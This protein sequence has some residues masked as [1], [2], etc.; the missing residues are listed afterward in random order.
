MPSDRESVLR[1]DLAVQKSHLLVYTAAFLTA[2]AAHVLGVFVLNIPLAIAIGII[3]VTSATAIYMLLRR[4]VSRRILNPIWISTDVFLV[5]LGVYA[6]GGSASPWFIWYLGTSASTA[7]VV[8]KRASYVV[9]VAN[10]VAYIGLLMA[11]GQASFVNSVMLLASTRML[12][13]FGASFFFLAGIA[14]LQQKHLLIRELESEQARELAEL[15]RLTAELQRRGNE[16]EDASRR[17]Q[18]ADRL[19]SQFLANMSHELRTPMNSIIGFSEIL[20]ER[21]NGAIDPKHVSFL[22]HILTSG[23][24]LL[25]IINDILDLSKIE[26]GKMEVYAEKF[27]V[28]PVIESVCTVMRG[29]A[30]TKMPTFVIEADSTLPAVETDLAKFKQILYNLLSNAMKFSPAESPITIRTMHI[31]ETITISVRDGGIGIDP[32]NHDVIFEEFR[33][34]DGSARREFG[35]TGLGLALVKKFVQ[36]QGGW[37]RVE[38]DRGKGSTFSFTLPIHSRAAVVSRIPEL[39]PSEQRAERVLVVE[40]D[41]HAYDLIATA[42]NSAGYLSVRARHGDEAIRLAREARPIAVTLDLVL[43]GI[44]GWE[45]LKT[46]KSDAATRDIPVV[47]IS[48]VDE[49]DLG[50]ALGADDYFVKPVDRDRLLNRVRQLT[51]SDQSKTR[52]LLIDDDTSL[53][54]LLDEELTRLGYTIESAFNG[55]TGFAA[56]K[57]N[58][59]DVI[60]LDLMMPGMSFEVAGLL[61]NNPS[62]AR[63]PILVLTSKEISADDRKELQSKVAAC[64]QKGTSARDQLVAEIRRLRSANAS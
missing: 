31:G 39:V 20:I 32:K 19:K 5:T 44:D 63:I 57:E 3:S 6:T 47:I 26:A 17:I 15:T 48:R 58:A 40:D 29:M 10:A 33:Q 13:L 25:G 35:G 23:Q 21:L 46:L 11:M 54:E 1:F 41:A 59:P 22:R 56:A 52:L 27:E 7:F 38:S 37:V 9:S 61:K 34:I 4:G 14:N 16:L 51:T 36:L 18:E 62:T 28:R 30:K 60:I 64:V 43:P 12:F 53:H 45:V 50:V 42:L 24:H 8:G 55:E 2:L 49:R